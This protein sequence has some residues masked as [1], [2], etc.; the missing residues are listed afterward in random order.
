MVSAVVPPGI[1]GDAVPVI[2][3]VDGQSSQ[4]A[5]MAVTTS[6]LNETSIQ[7][8]SSFNPSTYGENV[9]LTAN[10]TPATATGTVTFKDG[11]ST[12]GSGNLTNGS[13]SLTLSSLPAG[14]HTLTAAYSGDSRRTLHPHSRET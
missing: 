12:L 8:V 4:S 14:Q 11:S 6:Q 3:T 10:V 1:S 9:I 5:T 2:V 13:A 7:L